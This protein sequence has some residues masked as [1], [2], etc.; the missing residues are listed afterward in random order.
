MWIFQLKQR[1]GL[2]GEV[3]VENILKT[4]KL[5]LSLVSFSQISYVMGG[6]VN[7]LRELRELFLMEV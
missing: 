5:K 6:M 2:S 7:C 4:C 3:E 1:L